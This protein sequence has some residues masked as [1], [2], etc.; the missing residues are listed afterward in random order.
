MFQLEQMLDDALDLTAHG[1]Q[2]AAAQALD[3]LGQVLQIEGAV[4]ARSS[5]GAQFRRLLP[6]PGI[7]VG[8][9]ERSFEHLGHRPSWSSTSA[10]TK[11]SNASAA[12]GKAQERAGSAQLS[13][14]TCR[15]GGWF[16]EKTRHRRQEYRVVE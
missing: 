2:I 4:D 12:A 5:Q 13:G 10:P 8:L 3:L 16:R 15:P 1:I 11:N 7:V 6:G 14:R 9:V